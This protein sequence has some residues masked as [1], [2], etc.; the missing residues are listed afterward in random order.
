MCLLTDVSQGA[1][2]WLLVLLLL[3]LCLP[4]MTRYEVF[5]T[6]LQTAPNPT[7]SK[8]SCSESGNPGIFPSVFI[9]MAAVELKESVYV[10]F[11]FGVSEL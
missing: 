9:F 6:M 7:A 10:S 11:P 2:N 4:I 3:L 5:V 1:V 8:V